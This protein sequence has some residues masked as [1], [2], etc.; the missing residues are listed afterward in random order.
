MHKKGRD[1]KL[2][3]AKPVRTRLLRL[4][5]HRKTLRARLSKWDWSK[6]NAELADEAGLSR[7]P[8]RQIR[9]ALGAPDP[10]HRSYRRRKTAEDLQWAKD[11][12]EKLKGLCK[13]ELAR[14]YGVSRSKANPI[15]R[16]LEPFL[17]D[18]RQKYRW[19]LM[20][21]SLPSCD[22]ERIWRLPHNM[23]ASYRYRKRLPRPAWFVIEGRP[24]A[25]LSGRGQLQAYRRAV[26]AEERFAA[27][28][29]AQV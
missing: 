16:F 13:A 4:R 28:Y 21:F 8:L 15:I 19:D 5:R 20:T 2:K 27:R 24:Y 23:A 12:L 18:A 25:R 1:L 10:P 7:E 9:H 3:S 22:L 11:N 29:L 26:K 14:K 6:S 17:R